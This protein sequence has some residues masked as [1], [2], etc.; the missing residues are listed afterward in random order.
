MVKYD[1]TY[2]SFS[3]HRSIARASIIAPETKAATNSIDHQFTAFVPPD[4]IL[5][6]MPSKAQDI[7]FFNTT[8][9]NYV[10]LSM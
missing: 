10:S 5:F 9:L 3:F 7:L 6:P 4:A 8:L 1:M 2:T